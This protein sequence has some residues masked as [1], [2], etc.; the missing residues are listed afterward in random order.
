MYIAD[1]T[2]YKK[3]CLSKLKSAVLV[4]LDHI[5]TIWSSWS[6]PFG[7]H[8]LCQSIWL[9]HWTISS[10]ALDLA[11]TVVQMLVCFP[12][13]VQSV[14][15]VAFNKIWI[16]ELCTNYIVHENYILFIGHVVNVR[17][18][19]SYVSNY[20]WINFEIIRAAITVNTESRSLW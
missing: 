16:P 15:I 6:C 8:P 14:D 1:I 9:H 10:C 13:Q 18:G 2:K 4:P 7:N 19:L 5:A 11:Y 17:A 3:K 12:L 20:A